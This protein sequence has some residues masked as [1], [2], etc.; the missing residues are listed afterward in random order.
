M[1]WRSQFI[2]RSPCTRLRSLGPRTDHGVSRDARREARRRQ[3]AAH[4]APP[5]DLDGDRAR[6]SFGERIARFFGKPRPESVAL[7]AVGPPE[8][9]AGRP[10]PAWIGADGP[11]RL[12]TFREHHLKL[13]QLA[14]GR[15]W[16][17]SE[18]TGERDG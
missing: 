13:E 8:V 7:H 16:G 17:G 18:G 6:V 9:V 5:P 14:T 10:A 3:I 4:S 2:T 15:C 12:P 1:R 11:E